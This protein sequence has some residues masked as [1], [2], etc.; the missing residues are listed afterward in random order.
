MATAEGTTAA[1]TT[2]SISVSNPISKFNMK[3]LWDTG[4]A[5]WSCDYRSIASHL[6]QYP[7]IKVIEGS[8]HGFMLRSIDFD[9]GLKP[10][11]NLSTNINAEN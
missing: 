5:G 9:A 7:H 3:I 1:K 6:A 11:T 10:R 8:W 2:E 4:R